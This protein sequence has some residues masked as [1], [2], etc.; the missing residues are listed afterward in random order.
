MIVRINLNPDKKV[1]T[2]SSPNTTIL[3]V[4]IIVLVLEVLVCIVISHNQSGT[5]S[6]YL[7]EE[8]KRVAE[9]DELKTSLGSVDKMK[10]EIEELRSREMTFAKLAA[11]RTGPQYVLN[12]FSRLLSNPRDVVARK[13]AQSADWALAWDPENIII[14]KFADIGTSQ[15]EIE[16]TARNM[17]D[18]SEFWK[19]MK[20]SPLMRNVRL[21]EIK[22]ARDSSLSIVTQ[23]F[24]FT[25]DVN[26]N[27][28]TQGG[29]ATIDMLTTEEEPSETNEPSE[30]GKTESH[31]E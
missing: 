20:T 25:A 3:L 31:P 2:K 27:Y 21:G 13:A 19:R 9:R 24:S 16:G 28:Q 15:I 29:L 7:N 5:L 10:K 4:L 17:D 26:F 18:I 23:S 14:K 12:E 30:D 11:L 8:S 6:N 1:K 22:D